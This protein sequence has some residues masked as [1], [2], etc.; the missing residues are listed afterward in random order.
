MQ[1]LKWLAVPFLVLAASCATATYASK[2][3]PGSAESIYGSQVYVYSFLDVRS[4][5]LGRGMVEQVNQQLLSQLNARGV[6][7]QIVTYG[8]VTDKIAVGTVQVPVDEIIASYGPQEAEFGADF[9]LVVMPTQMTIYGATQDY[10]VSWQ[11]MSVETGEVVWSTT[12]SGGRTVWWHQNED[13]EDR[14]RA[15]VD[16]LIAEMA[17]SGLFNTTSDFAI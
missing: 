15:V 2:N 3:E 8:D 9:R 11:L 1:I 16:G 17:A 12:L 7:A 13:S 6:A 14:A 5:D 10:Q 4:S